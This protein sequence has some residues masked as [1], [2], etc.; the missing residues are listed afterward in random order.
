MKKTIL[1]VDDEDLVRTTMDKVLTQAGYDVICAAEARQALEVLKAEQIK[2][3]LLD[4]RMP[5]MDGIQL[6]REIRRTVGSSCV[7]YAMTAHI[8]DYEVEECRKAGFDDY[9]VKP[10]KMAT[11]IKMIG[12]AFETLERWQKIE[13]SRH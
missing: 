13:K 12:L 8:N 1:I 7:I 10:F 5:G 3:F 9:F 4:L 11:I 2:V 6:C